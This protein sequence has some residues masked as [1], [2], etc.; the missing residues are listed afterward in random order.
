MESGQSSYQDGA[1]MTTESVWEPER[2][3]KFY[4][5]IMGECC[6]VYPDVKHSTAGWILH[7]HVDGQWVTERK[8]TP[9]DLERL[10]KAVIEAHHDH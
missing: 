10:N 4:D 5:A 6:Y 3:L 2:C 8:A 9:D 1:L 7:R